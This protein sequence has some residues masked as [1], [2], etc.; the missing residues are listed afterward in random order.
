MKKFLILIVAAMMPFLAGAQAQINT[1][2]MKI[3][4]FPQKVT[5]VV[6]PETHSMTAHSRKM[7]PQ[8]GG[9]L[10][11]SSVPSKSLNL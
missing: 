7:S 9:F 4:D 2:K 11:M 1:K 8:D 3:A 6:L 5:K 10:H